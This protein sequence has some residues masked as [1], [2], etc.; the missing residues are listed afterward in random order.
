MAYGLSFSPEFFLAEGEPYDRADLALN[1][2]GQPVSVWSAIVK[3]QQ[4]RE[5]WQAMCEDCFPGVNPEHVQ[6]ESVL[7]MVEQTNTCG[8]LRT[9]VDVWID[10][11]G[12]HTLDI[13]ED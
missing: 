4:D 9:P 3:L 8:D 6:P 13:Y 2:A 5:S 1:A 12:Y 10:S 11:K 7:E